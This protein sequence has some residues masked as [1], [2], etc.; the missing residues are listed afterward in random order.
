MRIV[1]DLVLKHDE[2]PIELRAVIISSFKNSLSHYMNGVYY[3]QYYSPAKS[4]PFTFAPYLGKA[5]FERDKIIVP[6]KRVKIFF[7]TSCME[8]GL[9]FYNAL[10]QQ[11]KYWYPLA[12]GNAMRLE[13]IAI[14]KEE[15]IYHRDIKISFMSPLCVR[16]HAAESNKDWYYSYGQEHFVDNLREVLRQQVM[17]ETALS[18]EL[19]DS[20]CIEAL[21]HKKTVIKHHNQQIEVTL[22]T[23]YVHGDIQLLT[24]L[25]LAGMGSRKSAGMGY[26][27]ILEQGGEKAWEERLPSR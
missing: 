25:Y 17:R 6:G 3:E 26:F 24:H 16:Q 9:I 8:T 23:F 27:N 21:Q 19:V 5:H 13:H 4:K 2:V 14:E 1:L 20:L 18:V 12:H 15:V 7:S 22:G 10:L 11:K